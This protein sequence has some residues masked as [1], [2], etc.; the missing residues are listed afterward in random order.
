MLLKWHGGKTYLAKT[1]HNL[2]PSEYVT[3][4][5][6]YAGAAQ[7]MWHWPCPHCQCVPPEHEPKCPGI[8]EILNDVDG[9]LV[10]F[11]QVLRG[12]QSK[13]FRS[14]MELV[15]F[16]RAEW[17]EAIE[18][19]GAHNPMVR[20]IAFFVRYRQSRQ[21]LGKD[22][23]TLSV[24]RTRRQRNEQVSSWQS[25]I[26][27]LNEA[28]Q[29]LR[30]VVVE[31]LPALTLL[32]KYDSPNTFFYLDPP[33]HPD[34]RVAGE[35][36]YEMSVDD[37]AELLAELCLLKGKFLLSGYDNPLYQDWRQTNVFRMETV[38]QAAHSS[39]RKNKATRQ[40]CFW[41]NY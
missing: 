6:P 37:H 16:S 19:T 20:A 38:E 13:Q 24:N 28:V 17:E 27:E 39:S 25:A 2:A 10:N 34:T 14:I 15:P 35:Y 41:M 30:N 18:V 12:P 29:R 33:Y 4:I 1:I 5:H 11:F 36:D 21:G 40:E 22:F 3:R 32:K 9:D 31:S 26:E 8:S 7:E 23:A